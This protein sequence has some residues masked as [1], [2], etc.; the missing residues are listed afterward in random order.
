[1]AR[2]DALSGREGPALPAT[3]TPPPPV[4]AAPVL[5]VVTTAEQEA[6]ATLEE[7]A[8]DPV[9]REIF[10]K[11]TAGH[12]LVVRQYLERCARGAPPHP[13]SEALHRA[14]HTLSGIAKTAGA[15]QG[16]KVAEPMEHY[17]RK[18][19]DNGHGMG[20]DGLELL[21][22]TVRVLETVS[23]HVDENTGFFPEQ[24]RLTTGWIAL[25]RQLDVE[26]ARLAEAAERTLGDAWRGGRPAQAPPPVVIEHST[27][28]PA[29]ELTE[30]SL[31]RLS[32][33]ELRAAE[34]DPDHTAPHATLSEHLEAEPPLAVPATEPPQPAFEPALPDEDSLP[35]FGEDFDAD[36]AAI[37]GEEAT[38]LL[39]QAEAA[40][41]RWRA[42]RADF[43]QVTELKRLLH[44]LK[45]G[46]R[47]A[48]IRAMGDLSH[49]VESF[50]AVIE[51]GTSQA[52]GAALEVLQ[53]S[54]DELHRMREM[55]NSG[56]RIPA[57]RDLIQQ[58]RS[59]A[60]APPAA[61]DTF[62][63]L[64]VEARDE[65]PVADVTEPLA[66]EGVA[67]IV[68]ETHAED[69]H[70][71][72]PYEAE[73]HEAEPARGRTARGSVAR[74]DR[75]RGGGRRTRRRSRTRT[76]RSR[77]GGRGQRRCRARIAGRIDRRATRHDRCRG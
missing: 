41:S 46:A 23:E 68:L 21:R 18:L 36:I 58:L 5:P 42:D 32:E 65:E 2:A 60:A 63:G 55:A 29:E 13:V 22:D 47:M 56:Q 1:M 74:G 53:A 19:F 39:E 45:G 51:A 62:A 8:M 61:A 75:A 7:P 15:R 73:L 72:A 64:A 31:P 10:R 35:S 49:E 67:E 28:I 48:G 54:L 30:P 3:A 9:L 57:A 38:E 50:L 40:F 77:A 66:D 33:D 43:A 17:V 34:P 52:D 12:I 14:C 59:L 70:E 4:V 71:E 69:L 24:T 25:E 11:E 37:F 20:A 6:P 76:V 26:L 44:T 16:I 27:P